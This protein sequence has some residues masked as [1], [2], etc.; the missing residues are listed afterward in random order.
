[1]ITVIGGVYDEICHEPQVRRTYGS[2]VRAAAVLGGCMD[3]LVTIA[4]ESSLEL[5]RSVLG[6]CTIEAA[7]RS[8]P[9]TF[10]YDTPVSPPR[11]DAHDADRRLTIPAVETDDALI[12]GMVEGAATVRCHRAVI[13]PQHSMSAGQIAELVTADELVVVANRREVLSLGTGTGVVEAA[14]SLRSRLGASAVVVK[15]GALGALVVTEDGAVGIPVAAT[16]AVF[17]IGSGD[18]FSAALAK[19][20]FDGATIVEAAHAASLRT[21]GYCATR[22]LGPVSITETT[23]ALPTAESVENPPRIYVAASFSNP[24]QRWAA[25]TITAGIEDLGARAFYPLR[26]VGQV[27]NQRQT[28]AADLD[29]LAEC[30]AV[31]LLADS[32][33][34]GPHFEA[35][36]AQHL[37]KPIVVVSTDPDPGR[38]TMLRGTGAEVVDDWSTAVYRVIW[39]AVRDRS[40]R[41]GDS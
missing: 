35:G 30:D 1:V 27:T 2:G 32:A 7:P 4:D 26:D 17:P 33:R 21:A 5:V 8:R 36:W 38:Y 20:W 19:A 10:S 6:P 14:E 25:R 34:S 13:D 39:A 18:V 28:A 41:S 9:V 37:D 29:G 15:C 31:L 12:F 23:E 16:E 22:Q 3:R 40:R 11:L 24:E